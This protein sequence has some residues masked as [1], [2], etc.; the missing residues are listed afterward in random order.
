[1][2]FTGP[3]T[4]STGAIGINTTGGA[5]PGGASISFNGTLN[6]AEALTL[7]AG[8]SGTITFGGAVGARLSSDESDLLG[9]PFDSNRS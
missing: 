2:S 3:V 5:S 6:G 1:M 9:S 7:N 4:L 8:T